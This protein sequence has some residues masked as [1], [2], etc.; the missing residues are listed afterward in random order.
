MSG[1]FF[2]KEEGCRCMARGLKTTRLIGDCETAALVSRGG[3]DRL[4]VLADVFF[5]GVFCG[6]AGDAEN[7]FW[8]IRP[9]EDVVEVRRRYRPGTM[10]R[11]DDVCDQ[12]RRGV[13]DGLHAAA[14]KAL[15]CGADGAGGERPGEDAH[16]PGAAIRLWAD[17][18]VGDQAWGRVACGCGAGHGGVA[19]PVHQ[20]QT[21]GAEGRRHEDGERLCGARD[22]KARAIQSASR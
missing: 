12:G 19:Q 5:G 2:S 8:R 7:G 17:G 14:G 9:V 20:R 18:A 10:I 4:V 15:G 16:G 13:S 3:I 6:A 22:E 11:R 21:G 1:G